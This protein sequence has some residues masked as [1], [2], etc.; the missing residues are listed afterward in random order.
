MMLTRKSLSTIGSLLL[1]DRGVRSAVFSFTLTRTIILVIFLLGTNIKVVEPNRVF[2]KD[3]EEIAISLQEPGV[4]KRL[5]ALAMR[6][7]GGWYWHIADRGYEK[8][9]F[10]QTEPHNWAFFP[11]F[12]LLWNA[13][14]TVTGEFP[15]TGI[16]LANLFFFFAL[17]LLHRAALSF[18]LDEAAADRTL[19]YVAAF[20]ASYFFSIP[21]SE[22][23]FLLLTVGSFLAARRDR[24]WLASILAALAATTR[25][26]GLLL[27]PALL[28]L[29]WQK[30]SSMKPSLKTLSL[31]I[32]PMGTL[33]YMLYL[34]SI[35]G[36]AFAFSAI[37]PAWGRKVQFFVF[38]LFEYLSS[39]LELSYKW[40]FKLLNFIA[41][42]LAVVCS[43]VLLRRRQWALGIYVLGAVLLP[44]SSGT[45][46][47]MTRYSM[48]AFPIFF[49]LA[50]AGRSSRV[51]QIIRSVFLVLL[52]IMTLLCTIIVTLALS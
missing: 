23:L 40:N 9:P 34:R 17:L 42:L 26:S 46:Q 51:D 13:A 36:N 30:D 52:G 29:Q 27:L 16:F 48:V 3:A 39:P 10:E 1:R 38:T 21:V 8:I 2:G 20:P 15:F 35:T 28:I 44:L 11:L 12:P 41:A 18:G 25:L 6:G 31:S 32:I 50:Q 14:A 7:D 24:W 43:F 37:Q 4:M 22:S 19:F 49:V 45:L 33:G 5:S 47:S